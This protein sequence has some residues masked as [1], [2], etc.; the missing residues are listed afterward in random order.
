MARSRKPSL[1]RDIFE[2][3]AAFPWWVGMVTAIGLYVGLHTYASQASVPMLSAVQFGSVVTH[4]LFKTL[5]GILQYLLPVICLGAAAT[6]AWN[7]A[8]R[9]SLA[10]GVT[11]S[12]SVAALEGMSW[13]EFEILVGEAFRQKGF[14]VIELGGAGPDGGVDLVLIKGGEVSLVQCKQWK[15]RKVGVDVV[16]E[17]YGVMAAKGAASGYVVTSGKFTVDAQAFARGRNVRMVDGERLLAMLQ[18]AKAGIRAARASAGVPLASN[19]AAMPSC[20]P[21][22]ARR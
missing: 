5:A 22:T 1:L 21:H 6:S 15:A 14:K 11:A 13:Q 18:S 9:Q 4:T 10:E 19:Q 3:A 17:L 7:V 16:R 8:Q 12:R 20:P 2:I